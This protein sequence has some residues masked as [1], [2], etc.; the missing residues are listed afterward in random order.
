MNK[1]ILAIFLAI[2]VIAGGIWFYDW[3]L[4]NTLEAS[5]PIQAIPLDIETPLPDPTDVVGPL[6]T[7]LPGPEVSSPEPEQ[8][9]TA[10]QTEIVPAQVE[11]RYAIV[12]AESQARFTIFE[13]LNGIPTDVIGVT[14]QVAG[15]AAVNLSDLSQTRLGVI[16][17][18]ARALATDQDRRNQ[19]IRNRILLTDQYEYITFTPT[20]IN[21][22]SSS[23]APGQTFNF[24]I[25]GDLTIRDITRPVEFEASVAV[26]SS[27]RLNGFAEAVIAKSD[28]NLIVPNVPFVANVGENVT[29]EI[30]FVLTPAQP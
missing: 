3:V 11:I 7:G 22:L 20:E 27:E 25:L 14:D 28:F 2:A 16:Q 29:L 6:E 9:E 21:G 19:A 17:V 26:A 10:S 5:E 1:R 8:S 23:A 12:Q 4:G 18:N 13:E 15:E 30:D 24:R